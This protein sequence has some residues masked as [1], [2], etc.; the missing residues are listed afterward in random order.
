VTDS[1]GLVPIAY[2]PDILDPNGRSVGFD[3]R[4]MF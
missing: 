2:Q 4:K 3:F 1:T